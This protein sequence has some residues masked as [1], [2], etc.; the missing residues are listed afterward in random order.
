MVLFIILS[1]KLTLP[2]KVFLVIE[3][4]GALHSME[5]I[6]FHLLFTRGLGFGHV[7]E[8]S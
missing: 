7:N 3:E 6:L 4:L 8:P 2:F 1:T 5:I